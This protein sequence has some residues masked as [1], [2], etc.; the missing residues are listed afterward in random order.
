MLIVICAI[1]LQTAIPEEITFISQ[2]RGGRQVVTIHK[3]NISIENNG[4]QQSLPLT[5]SDWDNLTK[6]IQEL[7][8]K[9]I[10]AYAAPSSA[11]SRDAAWHSTLSIS[12]GG[13][14]YTSSTFDD[15]KA[16]KELMKLMTCITRLRNKYSKD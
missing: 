4:L 10:P 7:D 9:E 2:T 6:T 1:L 12:A 14:T 8:Y 5:L 11:R 16:P 15:S 13:Y 3:D